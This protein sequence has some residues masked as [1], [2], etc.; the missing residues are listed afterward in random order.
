MTCDTIRFETERT[1]SESHS[2]G[3]RVGKKTDRHWSRLEFYGLHL[4]QQT[5]TS[6]CQKEIIDDVFSISKCLN[7]NWVADD[8]FALK[9]HSFS[10]DGKWHYRNRPNATQHFP[11]DS[12]E[13][14]HPLTDHRESNGVFTIF[15]VKSCLLTETQRIST[16]WIIK[17]KKTTATETNKQCLFLL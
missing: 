3:V 17:S 5:I 16:H 14:P 10:C 15:Q 8:D 12:R 6:L 2:T 1:N 9:F 11:T 13:K 4:T 7:W